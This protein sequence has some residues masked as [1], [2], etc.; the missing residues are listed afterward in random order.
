VPV[1]DTY[2][3]WGSDFDP[4]MALAPLVWDHWPNLVQGISAITGLPDRLCGMISAMASG[5]PSGPTRPQSGKWKAAYDLL[6]Q[7]C[8]KH[9]THKTY[10]HEH[11]KATYRGRAA[12][13]YDD[14]TLLHAASLNCKR[15][16]CKDCLRLWEP[17]DRQADTMISP[18]ICTDGSTY[19]GE[20]S[21][22][23]FFF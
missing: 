1:R 12:A 4:I 5:V 15:A 18:I 7:P 14:M 2:D 10:H 3:L 13:R 21:A 23:F 20:S 6:S 9:P 22:S 11:C 8:R 17:L 19:P 16:R